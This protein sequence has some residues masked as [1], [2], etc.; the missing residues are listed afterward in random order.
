MALLLNNLNQLSSGLTATVN[1]RVPLLLN[2][3]NADNIKLTL[4]NLAKSSETLA[5]TLNTQLPLILNEKNSE[6]ISL[7][8]AAAA[9]AGQSLEKESRNIGKLLETT[10]ALEKTASKT[11]NDYSLLSDNLS[12]LSA[13]MQTR[14]ESGEFDLRQMTEHHLEALNALLVELQMLTNQTNEVLQQL[15]RSPSDLLF[16]QEVI[17]PGP[18]E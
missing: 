4:T 10:L 15:K 11:L 14:I 8:L 16:K 3:E 5:D 6:N 7:T 18:G 13:S 9:Q 12:E 2:Q 17:K 1:E